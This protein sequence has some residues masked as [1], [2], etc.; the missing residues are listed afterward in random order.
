MG[1]HSTLKGCAVDQQPELPG[2]D[3]ATAP[4]SG[5]LVADFSRVL[6]GPLLTMTLA[7]LGARVIK[8]ERPGSGDDTR[9]WRPP[10]S[11]TGATY[12]ES[13]NR[14]KE[15]I[16]LDLRDPDDLAVA[17]ELAARADV[18]VENF[19][20]GGLDRLGLGWDSV[21]KVNPRAVY[22]SISGFGSAE[23]AALPG[24]DFIV[25]AQGGLMSITGDADGNPMKVGVALVDVLTAKDGAIAVLAALRERELTGVGRRVEVNLLSSLQGALANQVQSVIGAGV[26]P[27][28]IGNR[29]PSICPYETLRA[30]DALIAVAV[31]NDGQFRRL[32]ACLGIAE[33]ADDPRFTSNELRVAHR[34]ELVALLQGALATDTAERWEA[35]LQ[36]VGVPVGRVNSIAE[37]LELAHELG[38]EPIVPLEDASGDVVGAGIRHPVTWTPPLPERRSA[39]PTLD[40]HGAAVRAWLGEQ[41]PVESTAT[42]NHEDAKPGFDA[43][44]TPHAPSQSTSPNDV[45][46]DSRA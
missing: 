44:S 28:R 33:L 20:V 36:A 5:L 18:I 40:E 31:G 17:R 11:P 23:G 37:G 2:A 4:L 19:K 38:L 42:R 32:V 46:G 30:S 39:P 13:V 25:Q 6:A 41:E 1:V 43:V 9:A 29:H 3:G 35:R 45:E 16:A 24:Y 27:G 12:F 7:D 8:V 34:A 22:C 10:A 14:N 15:S 21:R 26:T